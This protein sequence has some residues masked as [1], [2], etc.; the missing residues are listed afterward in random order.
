MTSV[1]RGT[2]TLSRRSTPFYHSYRR[3]YQRG[4]HDAISADVSG[5]ASI[6]IPLNDNETVKI[7]GVAYTFNGT[8]VLDA[9]GRVIRFLTVL[10]TPYRLYAGSI[11]GL[12]VAETLNGMKYGGI[13]LYD[14]LLDLCVF[15]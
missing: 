10:E 5:N 3:G 2:R 14:I 15:K 7:N 9:N 4:D 1:C 11:I 6:Y 8:N 13:G 12:N